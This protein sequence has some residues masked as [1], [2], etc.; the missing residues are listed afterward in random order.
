[1]AWAVAEDIPDRLRALKAA[2]GCSWKE[3]AERAGVGPSQMSVWL[4]GRQKP[5]RSR[6]EAWANREGWS[7]DV[8]AA[9][10]VMPTVGVN[11][12]AGASSPAAPPPAYPSDP[13]ALIQAAVTLLHQ[14]L[15][16]LQ[17][18]AGVRPPTPDE[19]HAAIQASRGRGPRFRSGQG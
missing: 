7:L 9:G 13:T 11:R 18:P 6:L 4:S 3:L 14:A 8:F 2:L 19:V 5:S 17:P 12:P 16:A 1:M 10:R 15:A